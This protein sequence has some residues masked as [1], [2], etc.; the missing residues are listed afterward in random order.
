MLARKGYAAGLA[1]AVVRDELA[2]RPTAE[3]ASADQ[4]TDDART[5]TPMA[6]RDASGGMAREPSARS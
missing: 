1:F 5:L 3:K 6:R 2:E 4:P